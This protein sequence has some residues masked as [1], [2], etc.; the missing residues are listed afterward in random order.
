MLP[1]FSGFCPLS[2]THLTRVLTRLLPIRSR[3]HD[4][5]LVASACDSFAAWSRSHKFTNSNKSCEPSVWISK[6]WTLLGRPN[7]AKQHPM[8]MLVTI[9]N[10]L[11]DSFKSFCLDNK[12]PH[13][14]QHRDV[15]WPYIY[16]WS[17][18]KNLHSCPCDSPSGCTFSSA[19][20]KLCNTLW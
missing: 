1:L 4:K 16:P 7:S 14:H 13:Q 3:S 6:G 9:N 11:K 2:S 20:C 18:Q 10:E 19:A 8:Q 15:C 17:I 12:F 5:Q